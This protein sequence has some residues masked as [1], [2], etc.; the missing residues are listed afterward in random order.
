MAKL[1]NVK[2]DIDYLVSEVLGDCYTLIYLYPEKKESAMEIINNAIEFRNQLFERA[3]KPNGKADKKLVKIH[4]KSISTDLLTG[5]DN[6]FKQ[7]SE[8]TKK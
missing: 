5:I 3:N 7:I 8:L 2:K 6:L 1:R 4:Y